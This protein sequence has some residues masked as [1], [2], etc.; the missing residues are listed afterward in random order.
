MNWKRFLFL[1]LP[2]ALAVTAAVAEGAAWALRDVA[3]RR[4]DLDRLVVA[5]DGAKMDAPLVLLGDSVTQDVAKSYRLAPPGQVANLTTN[6]ASGAIGAALLLRRYL[7]HNQPPRLV[8]IAAT[9]DFFS[10]RPEGKAAETWVTSVFR[11]PDERAVLGRFGLDR[12][13][14]WRPAALVLETRLGEKV[15]GLIAPRAEAMPSGAQ[16]PGRAL[17]ET[18]AAPPEVVAEIAGRARQTLSLSDSARWAVQDMC[19]LSAQYGFT[20]AVLRAPQPSS[21]GVA[22]GAAMIA[23]QAQVAEA[24]RECRAVTFG[25]FNAGTVF[26][27]N[28]F[29]DGHH[30]RRPGWT[31]YY[32]RL[33]SDRLGT[34]IATTP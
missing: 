7:D 18:D 16:E 19:R 25:D 28:A 12:D 2:V 3:P 13:E 23:Q 20:L 8:V 31:S 5:L 10:Y 24:A 22:Q 29:R 6:L 4:H 11:R 17:P 34:L 15:Q 32:A 14:S 27:D 1:H 30:L 33:L 9:G 26:P 21:V